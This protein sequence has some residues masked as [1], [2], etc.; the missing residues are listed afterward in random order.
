MQTAADGSVTHLRDIARL[1]LGSVNYSQD[2]HYDNKIGGRHH[3][4]SAARG[5]CA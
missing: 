5:Q 2:F 3:D 4:L 1:E